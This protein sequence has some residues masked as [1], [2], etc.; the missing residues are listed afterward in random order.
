MTAVRLIALEKKEGLPLRVKLL[1]ELGRHLT[2]HPDW[3]D[4]LVGKCGR[5]RQK[6]DE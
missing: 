6:L 1:G 3:A 2:A 4:R 5:M